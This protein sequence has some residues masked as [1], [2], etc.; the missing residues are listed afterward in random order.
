MPRNNLYI[1]IT[2]GIDNVDIEFARKVASTH[3]VTFCIIPPAWET[4]WLKVFKYI[5]VQKLEDLVKPLK[6]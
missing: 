3:K 1:V 4:E 6:M 5:K 2:D